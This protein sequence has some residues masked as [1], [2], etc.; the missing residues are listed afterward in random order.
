MRLSKLNKVAI[1]GSGSHTRSSIN[2]LTHHFDINNITFAVYDD[3]FEDGK[4]ELIQ[5]IPLVGKID[6]I[7]SNQKV[8]L[9]IGNNKLRKRYFTHFRNQI[10][11]DNIFHLNSL[12]E[13]DVLFGIAN[14]VYANSFINS[15]ASIGENNIIN[16]GAIIEHEVRL[17][18]HNHISIGAKICGR[19]LVGDSCLI[20]AGAIV[21]DKISICDEVIIGAGTVVIND[22]LTPGTY[23]GNPARRIK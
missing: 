22:I 13:K 1:I 12:H 20:G 2:L 19:S 23:V 11:E 21:L 8:F 15:Y 9:S 14:Q 4:T 18:N 5:D 6:D 7:S 10:I 3:S 16:S 17:G